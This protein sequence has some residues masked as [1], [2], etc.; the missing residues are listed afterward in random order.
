[1]VMARDFSTTVMRPDFLG[2]NNGFAARAALDAAGRFPALPCA[3]LRA[4][5]WAERGRWD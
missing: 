4:R 1:M 3:D 5:W 2:H